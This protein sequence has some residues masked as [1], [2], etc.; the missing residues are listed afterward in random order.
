MTLTWTIAGLT[1]PWGNVPADIIWDY[2]L[3]LVFCL[4]ILALGYWAYR[5]SMDRAPL[6]VGIAFG[7]FGIYYVFILLG[8]GELYQTGI[9]ILRYL[10]YLV[11]A[12][13]LYDFGSRSVE[14]RIPE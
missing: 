3:R 13:A 14:I 4:I 11:V 12:Y 1:F 7:L 9:L 5:Q 6:L 2:G 10:G 8:L